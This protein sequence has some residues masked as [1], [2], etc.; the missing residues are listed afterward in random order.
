MPA[1]I[2]ATMSVHDAD[3]Y[4]RYTARTPAILAR[5]GGRFL[6]R[7]DPVTTLEGEPFGQRMVLLEFPDAA[8]ARAFYDDP[9]YQEVSQFRRAAASGGRMILQ[10]GRDDTAA[11]DPRL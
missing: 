4:R 7:G 9:E 5:H 3:T 2:V 8:A 6:T 10:E 1:Y 11:P